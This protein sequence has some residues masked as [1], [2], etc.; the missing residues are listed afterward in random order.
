MLTDLAHG[1]WLPNVYAI[2]H[3]VHA[4]IRLSAQVQNAQHL[5]VPVIAHTDT[6]AVYVRTTALWLNL[7][8]RKLLC[9]VTNQH[10]QRRANIMYII[11][12]IHLN[13]RYHTNLSMIY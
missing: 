3:D 2:H 9:I 11:L 12:S 10:S 7:L 5:T 1:T 6:A 4:V 8:S 13:L